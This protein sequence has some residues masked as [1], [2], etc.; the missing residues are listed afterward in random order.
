[1]MNAIQYFFY[2]LNLDI[3]FLLLKF[4]FIIFLLDIIVFHLTYHHLLIYS[5]MQEDTYFIF[6]VNNLDNP[7][8]TQ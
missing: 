8:R 3:I 4:Q 5:H 7:N 6:N 1:M 2:Y